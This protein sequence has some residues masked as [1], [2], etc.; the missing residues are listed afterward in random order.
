VHSLLSRGIVRN[1]VGFS[2]FGNLTETNPAADLIQAVINKTVDVAVAW[3]PLAGYISRDSAVPLTLTPIN[4]DPASP[5]LPFAFNIGMGV[6]PA[7][8]ALKQQLD[9]EIKRRSPDIRVL[10]RSYGIPQTEE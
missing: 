5:N 2:I 4:G 9:T 8:A 3:G 7:D 6:R 1:L 10:L